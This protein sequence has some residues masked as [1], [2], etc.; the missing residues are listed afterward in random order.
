[1]YNYTPLTNLATS[2]PA[3]VARSVIA[4]RNSD[5]PPVKIWQRQPC[6]FRW[7]CIHVS[8]RTL[9]WCRTITD[10]T[11]IYHSLWMVLTDPVGVVVKADECGNDCEMIDEWVEIDPRQQTVSW[12]HQLHINT[13]HHRSIIRILR[14]FSFLKFNEF[15]EFFFGWK[16]FGKNS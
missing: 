6:L 3:I 1:M 8:L 2:M 5:P 16:K 7:E 15:Y 13:T 14:I 12:R 4:S 9:V 10:R 11:F